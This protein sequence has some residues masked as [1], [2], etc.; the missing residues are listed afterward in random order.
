VNERSGVVVLSENTGAHAELSEW[1]ETINPYDVE[2]QAEAIHR[3]LTL[4]EVERR[5][6][7][8]AIQSQVR[9]HDVQAW[10]AL[11]LAALDEVAA[12]LRR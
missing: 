8:R 4:D 5:R 6:R 1:V 10:L 7:L 2:A 9:E 12:A 11:Q 3:A